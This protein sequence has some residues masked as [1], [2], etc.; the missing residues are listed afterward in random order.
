MADDETRA[1]AEELNTARPST[2]DKTS[3]LRVLK[4]WFRDDAS[5]SAKW[6]EE[7]K[8]DFDFRA[9]H[10]WTASE[11][12]QLRDQLRP[13]IVFNRSLTIIKAVAGFEIN[14][15]HEIQFLPRTLNDSAVNEVLTGA[16]K[17]MGDECEAEDEESEAFQDVVTCGMGWCEARIS[18]EQ[19]S[20]G[21]YEETE[22]NPLEMYWD[23]RARKRNLVDR[24]R[25]AR[26]R[27]LALSEAMEMFPGFDKT[28]LDARWAVGLEMEEQTKT[29]EEK[30]RREENAGDNYIER[31]DVHLVQ[32]Q[33]VERAPYWLVADEATNKKVELPDD[34]YKL[35]KARMDA[36]GMK[37]VAVKIFKREFFQAFIGAEIL[38]VNTAPVPDRF[39]FECQTGEQ[40]KN[41][42]TFFGLIRVMRD[43]QKWANKWLSQ[44]LHIMNSNAKGGIMAEPDAFDDQRQAEESYSKPESITWMKRGALGGGPGQGAKIMPKPQATFPSGFINL[45]EFAIS[46]LRDVTGINLELL[47][48]KDI[49][50]PGILEAQRKQ[51]GMT[52]LATMFDSLRRFRK[53]VGHIRLYYIQNYLSDGR[54]VRITGQDGAKVIPLIRD[55]CLGEYDVVVDDA[56]TSPNQ[57]QANWALIAPM[58]PM[59]KDQLMS[60][61]DLLLEILQFSPLPS[62]LIEAL[63][64]TLGKLS[65]QQQADQQFQQQVKQLKVADMVATIDQKQSTSE[66]QNAKAGATQATAMYDLA[67]ARDLLQKNGFDGLSQHLDAA[68]KLSQIDKEQASADNIR[69]KTAGQQAT[70]TNTHADTL[71]THMDTAHKGVSALIDAL[72]P[73]PQGQPQQQQPAPQP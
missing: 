54:L 32:M 55:K 64:T 39:T 56:P 65:P 17:W 47:G 53:R 42:G 28:Q 67:M 31:E 19:D 68:H 45:L 51:A 27:Q 8:E 59:F 4:T 9:G 15:R 73:I 49:N 35:L 52:V 5:H 37:L 14:S 6:R 26:L 48:Q 34:K 23:Y 33:W 7:A 16:S 70:T 13:E 63:R 29:I 40:D 3:M 50:Q 25:C 44:T 22:I 20:A 24:K 1:T 58:L 57:K 72:T 66:M 62:R 21:L 38:E 36:L 30:R 46:S 2:L 61:P 11:R 43:P 18:Y 71:N 41:K 60:N 10:Q 12:S 69:A